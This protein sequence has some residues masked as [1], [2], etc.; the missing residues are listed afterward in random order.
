MQEWNHSEG[1]EETGRPGDR[2]DRDATTRVVKEISYGKSSWNGGIDSQWFYGEIVGDTQPGKRSQKNELERSTIL[3]GKF[4]YTNSTISTGPFSIALLV[5]H[6]VIV[7][8]HF[9]G[10]HW[11]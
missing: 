1:K 5:Y 3:N 4:N 8:H 2:P 11:G 7:G 10:I 6:R 9:M